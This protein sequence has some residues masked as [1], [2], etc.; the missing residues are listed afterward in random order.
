MVGSTIQLISQLHVGLADV[1]PHN[2]YLSLRNSE[3][4]SRRYK[5]AQIVI[6]RQAGYNVGVL[7]LTDEVHCS[8]KM[9]H[10]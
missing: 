7:Y 5:L 8:E 3:M 10:F 1:M 4:C 6:E 2:R 9:R